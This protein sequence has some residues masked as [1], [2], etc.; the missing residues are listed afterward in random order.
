[1]LAP[2]GKDKTAWRTVGLSAMRKLKYAMTGKGDKGS[3]QDTR[4]CPSKGTSQSEPLKG[5]R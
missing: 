1:M 5:Q 3:L 2:L 4:T